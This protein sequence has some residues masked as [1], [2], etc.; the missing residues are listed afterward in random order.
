MFEQV[1]IGLS[2]VALL[3]SLPRA[4]LMPDAVFNIRRRITELFTHRMMGD[5]KM[6][7]WV[8][9]GAEALITVH[10]QSDKL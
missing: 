8:S 6:R 5:C 9:E 10:S 4:F 2:G 3:G 7:N 1:C